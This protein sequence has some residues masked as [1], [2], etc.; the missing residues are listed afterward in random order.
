MEVVLECVERV[1][2]GSSV[3]HRILEEPGSWVELDE[4]AGK[5][6]LEG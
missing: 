2:V 3:E 6:V 5:N 4:L 1:K